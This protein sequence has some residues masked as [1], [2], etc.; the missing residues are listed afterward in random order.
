MSIG[1]TGHIYFAGYAGSPRAKGV[2]LRDPAT[3]AWQAVVYG[4]QLFPEAGPDIKV[5]WPKVYGVTSS[6]IAI[7][8]GWLV[9]PGVDD[10]NDRVFWFF[11][12]G[13]QR[14]HMLIREGT[15]LTVRDGDQRTVA[16]ALVTQSPT[17]DNF[18]LRVKFRD[19][20]YGVFSL[21]F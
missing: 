7:L 18:A 10:T 8:E 6:G 13:T 20:T 4:E 17:G 2:W 12:P 11:D 1:A 19:E 9:G 16:W 14:H 15:E 3:E 21:T 5:R